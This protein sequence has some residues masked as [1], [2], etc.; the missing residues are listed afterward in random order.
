MFVRSGFTQTQERSYPTGIDSPDEDEATSDNEPDDM[1]APRSPT[2]DDSNNADDDK[3]ETSPVP[4]QSQSQSRRRVQIMNDSDND[5]DDKDKQTLTDNQRTNTRHPLK[6]FLYLYSCL[7]L[8]FH[9]TSIC[10]L[11]VAF[12][13]MKSDDTDSKKHK[14]R[15]HDEQHQPEKKLKRSGN[16]TDNDQ[17]DHVEAT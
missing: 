7:F 16:T 5:D 13:R 1:N 15:R 3:Q 4:S 10:F 9:V 12:H 2:V 8:L 14:K 6:D 17:S 11:L